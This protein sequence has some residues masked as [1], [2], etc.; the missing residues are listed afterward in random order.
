MSASAPRL[1]RESNYHKIWAR[2]RRISFSRK[3][4]SLFAAELPRSWTRPQCRRDNPDETGTPG[5]GT[6]PGVVSWPIPQPALVY[7]DLTLDRIGLEEPSQPVKDE[8]AGHGH[9]EAGSGADHRDLDG[10]VDQFHRVVRNP[11][12]LVPQD[13]DGPLSRDAEVS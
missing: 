5:P 1:T 2:A 7:I 3:F 4:R 10:D 12:V 13:D 8:R 11:V 9:V 6:R